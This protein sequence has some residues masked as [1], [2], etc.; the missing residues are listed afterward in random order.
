MRSIAPTK[1]SSMATTSRLLMIRPVNFTFNEETAVNNAFQVNIAADDTQLKALA[2]FD[3]FVQVLRDNGVDVLV[4]NDTPSPVTPDSIFP[5]NWI[6]F[7]ADGSIVLYPMFAANRRA[8]RKPSVI[9][10]LR[11][12]FMVRDVIDLSAWED[13]GLF[14]EGTGSMVLDRDR[15]L[16]YACLSP[17]TDESVMDEFC[18]RLGYSA[19]LFHANDASGSPIYHTNVLMCVADHYVVICLE[20]IAGREE[21]DRISTTIRSSGKELIPISL[22][23]LSQFAG[24]MLQVK[25]QEGQPL[26]VMSTRA[27]GSLSSEQL[28]RL[29]AFNRIV[30]SSLATIE[31][32]GGGSAR[33]MIAEV[34]LEPKK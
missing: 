28:E 8:E 4:V 2:E 18:N 21:R 20:S 16:A 31:T 11:G 22:A 6:S 34:F 12:H 32:N 33:C 26:L 17:R 5:N 27:F 30:H 15:H 25:N 1:Y 24:N 9:S 10:Q 23:Q 29:N 14:L 7:H 13:K 19:V 3:A